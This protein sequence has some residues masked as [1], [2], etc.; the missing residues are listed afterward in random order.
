MAGS[1]EHGVGRGDHPVGSEA[2]LLEHHVAFGAGP[3]ALDADDS[4]E[5]ADDLPPA[6]LGAGP[7]ADPTRD[8]P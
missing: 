8:V 2:K 5:F 3:E 4:P 1:F 6:L 7:D